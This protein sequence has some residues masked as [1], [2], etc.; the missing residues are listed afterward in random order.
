MYTEKEEM[1]VD[2]TGAESIEQVVE[3]FGGMTEE[4]ISESVNNIWLGD[5]ANNELVQMIIDVIS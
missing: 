3:W 2:R 4:E 1:V 5:P